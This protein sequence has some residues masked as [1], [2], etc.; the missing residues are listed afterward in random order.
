MVSKKIFNIFR[1]GSKT[2][3]LSSL[4]F[5]AN[6]RADVFYL[7]AFVRKADD[8]VDSIPQKKRQ[9]KNY[10][11]KFDK[12]WQGQNT[13]DDVISPFVSMCKRVKIEKEIVDSFL[14]SMQMDLKKTDYNTLDETVS[15]MYG[16]AEVIG[17]MMAK[18]MH[19]SKDSYKYAK[20]LGRAM[21]YANFIRDIQ[22]D[23][24][25]NRQYLPKNISKKFG[26]ADLSYNSYLKNPKG[27]KRFIHSQIKTFE[28]WQ[29]QAEEG[30]VYIPKRYRVPIKTAS[31]MYIWTMQEIKKDPSIVYRTQ[32]KPNTFGV[33]GNGI[34][35]SVSEYLW[36]Q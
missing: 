12:I 4:F 33:V 10:R 9:F 24:E 31:D 8:F 29:K 18:I 13:T 32:K 16:S 35:N 7:Y 23:N 34:R 2:Y 26:L 25:L 11:D 27:F 15:Y 3:F 22:I 1:K 36:K 19:L 20:L 21:Q 6:V 17:I 14:D 30:F 5:P 28:T